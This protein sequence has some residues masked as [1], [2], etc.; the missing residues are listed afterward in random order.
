MRA[1]QAGLES[2]DLV[3]PDFYAQHGYPHDAWTRL[4]REAP[5]FWHERP[6]A[7]PFWA[8]TKHEDIVK[9][10]RQPRL[11]LNRPR[12]AIFTRELEPPDIQDPPTRHLLN[13]DPPD[14][15][16]FRLLASRRF[17]PRALRRL[18]PQIEE[19][20]GQI[21]DGWAERCTGEELAEGD[22]VVD[23]A[24]KLPL[25]V[26]AEMLGVPRRDWHLLFQWTNETIG[27]TD[28]EYQEGSTPSQTAERARIALFGYFHR[29]VQERRAEPT[30]DLVS[31]LANAEIDGHR[32]H[33]L[34]LLSYFYVLVVAGNETTRN[35]TSGGLLALIEHPDEMQ[36]LR[37]EPSLLSTGVEEILRWSTPVIQFARTASEDTEIRGQKIRAGESLALFYPSANRDEE[38]FEEPFAFRVAREPN[39]HLAFGIGEHFCLGAHLARLELQIIF[40]ELLRRLEHVELA[41]PVDRLRSSFVGGIKHMPVRYKMSARSLDR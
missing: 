25:A 26:I 22:F 15:G 21:L 27:S 3:S 33:D 18:E 2:I 31:L 8:I 30:E 12:L 4:R 39:P 1:D 16:Q 10:A 28:P 34:E 5:V 13:M 11:F 41:G 32:L 37:S 19:I 17:T 38:V 35:A 36:R 24:A 20:A 9:I 40:R 29:M 7:A 6:G 23:V 14:H